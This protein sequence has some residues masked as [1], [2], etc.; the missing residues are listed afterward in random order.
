MQR[1]ASTEEEEHDHS[2]NGRDEPE[3]HIDE[4]DPD[5]V[6]HPPDSA[7]AF[8]LLMNVHPGE[9][10]EEGGKKDTAAQS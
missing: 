6:L 3:Q 4:I 8:R 1:F 9:K 5:S 7:V 2:V 10:T